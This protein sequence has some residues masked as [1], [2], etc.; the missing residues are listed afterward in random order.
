VKHPPSDRRVSRLNRGAHKVLAPLVRRAYRIQVDGEGRLPTD[1]P[2]ILAPNHR[3]FMDSIFL[4]AIAPRPV[5]F[6]AKAEYF[7]RWST[8]RLL[9]AL[10]QIPLRRGSP[11]AARE[12]MEESRRVLDEGGILGIYPE[13]T[14]SRDGLLHRGNPGPARLALATGAPL[15]PVGLVGTEAVQEVGR[16]VPRVG[17][18]VGVR[19]GQP[20]TVSAPD[21]VNPRALVR[22][23]TRRLMGDI[24]ALSG[25]R[26]AERRRPSSRNRSD[27]S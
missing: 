1:G 8:R 2:M 10:D 21:G 24:A 17:L 4:S 16:R 6:V 9:T 18:D 3:S 19:F 12:T 15:V 26:R 5:S 27:H 23:A 22:D 25:Q 20:F 11:A 13:G 7:E 14:R